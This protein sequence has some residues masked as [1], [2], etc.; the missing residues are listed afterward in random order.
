MASFRTSVRER[1]GQTDGSRMTYSPDND[2]SESEVGMDPYCR[3]NDGEDSRREGDVLTG[4]GKTIVARE[5]FNVLHVMCG[6]RGEYSS[7]DAQKGVL[8]TRPP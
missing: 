5:N 4:C 2:L 1:S 8:L 7:Q 6:T 3:R